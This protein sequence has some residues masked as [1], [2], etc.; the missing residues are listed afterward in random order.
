M[1]QHTIDNDFLLMYFNYYYFYC[2]AYRTLFAIKYFIDDKVLI[3]LKSYRK[4]LTIKAALII[5]SSMYHF[6]LIALFPKYCIVCLYI[7]QHKKQQQYVFIIVHCINIHSERIIMIH[8]VL[9]CVIV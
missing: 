3:H 4:I 5:S 1:Q 2:D 8:D 6:Y 9:L 7:S